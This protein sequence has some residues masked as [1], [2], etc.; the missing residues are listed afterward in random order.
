MEENHNMRENTFGGIIRL[1]N[2]ENTEKNRER[3]V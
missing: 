3:Y 1:M 2:I